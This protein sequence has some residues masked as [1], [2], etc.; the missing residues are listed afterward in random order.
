[1]K[2]IVI[3][4]GLLIL[5]ALVEGPHKPKIS[6]TPIISIEEELNKI[7]EFKPTPVL[8]AIESP[9]GDPNQAYLDE[10][11]SF[12]KQPASSQSRVRE[13]ESEVESYKLQVSTLNQVQSPK[14]EPSQVQAPV[15][16][17]Y[18]YGNCSN[19]SC[20]VTYGSRRGLFGFR[21]R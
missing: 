3:T 9:L 11:E 1:M 8:E 17:S 6:L 20:S 14:Q 2:P 4:T 21:R 19:G 7:P 5:G 13:L 15:Y 12:K 10:I 16:K 18:T